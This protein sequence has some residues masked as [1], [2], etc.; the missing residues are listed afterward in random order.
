MPDL[1]HDEMNRRIAEFMEYM[2]WFTYDFCSDES[3]RSLL[4]GVEQ[5]LDLF[6]YG[7]ALYRILSE[8]LGKVRPADYAMA[9]AE[10]RCRAICA[11]LDELEAGNAG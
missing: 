10:A 5:K 6:A 8:S 11:V 7:D 3:P 9:P 1:T 4:M 2:P